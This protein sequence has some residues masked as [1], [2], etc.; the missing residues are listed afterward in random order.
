MSDEAPA[1]RSLPDSGPFG[2]LDAETRARLAAAGKFEV[3]PNGSAVAV[4]GEPH[5]TLSV[6][7]D[8]LKKISCHAHGDTVHLADLGTGE[9]VGEMSV[10]DPRP[11]SANAVVSGGPALIWS[12]SADAF[13]AFVERD[14]KLGSQI[15]KAIAK[16][17]CQRLRHNAESM[18]NREVTVR[19]HYREMD[20]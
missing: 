2:E 9:T 5:K 15:L 13:D 14:P 10:I 4:Q 8:S 20:Y 19:D 16:E 3:M 17:L 1:S 6:V 7:V 18:L 11:S 12:I